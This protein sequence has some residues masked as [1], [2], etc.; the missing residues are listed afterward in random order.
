MNAISRDNGIR[1]QVVTIPMGLREREAL[2]ENIQPD[3]ELWT[4]SQK[5]KHGL[6]ADP[7]RWKNHYGSGMSYMDEPR[8]R[9]KGRGRDFRAE[10]P[11]PRPE[12]FTDRPEYR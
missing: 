4:K 1:Y 9:R 10:V 2:A 12:D 6:T 7:K 5:L 8:P 11:P 3:P